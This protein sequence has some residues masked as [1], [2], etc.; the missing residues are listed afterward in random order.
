MTSDLSIDWSRPMFNLTMGTVQLPDACSIAFNSVTIT[1]LASLQFGRRSDPET[2]EAIRGFV[3]SFVL[4]RPLANRLIR[5]MIV[6]C[7]QDKD[8]CIWHEPGSDSA[9]ILRMDERVNVQP[10]DDD[11]DQGSNEQEG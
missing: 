2:W 4:D 6:R 8:V 1:E 7:L 9:H 5:K 3:E 11:P 10:G